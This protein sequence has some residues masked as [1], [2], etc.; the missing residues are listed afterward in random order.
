MAIVLDCFSVNMIDPELGSFKLSIEPITLRSFRKHLE[1]EP[2]VLW[3]GK[4]EL[5]T[6][7]C[8]KGLQDSVE[9]T[10]FP[11][12]AFTFDDVLYVISTKHNDRGTCI[13]K[14]VLIEHN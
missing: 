1:C 12:H 3:Q 2:D 8:P 5:F 10:D 13:F 7:F 9:L 6:K 11:H 4:P 14:R